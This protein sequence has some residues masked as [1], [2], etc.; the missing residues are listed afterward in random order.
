[1]GCT[2]DAP[3]RRPSGHPPLT[4]RLGRRT[5]ACVP[6]RAGSAHQTQ[7]CRAHS[8]MKPVTAAFLHLAGHQKMQPVVPA[9]SRGLGL[10]SPGFCFQVPLGAAQKTPVRMEAPVWQVPVPTAVTAGQASRAGAVSWVSQ[11]GHQ[12]GHW[13]PGT[14]C[15][16]CGQALGSWHKWLCPGLPNCEVPD[17]GLRVPRYRGWWAENLRRGGG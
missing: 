17:G 9:G 8:S 11:S 5:E 3:H 15:N 6:I 12:A 16:G 14:Y 13:L 7:R 1:M 4:L 10:T 2:S